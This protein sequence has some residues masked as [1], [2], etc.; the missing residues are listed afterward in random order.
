MLNSRNFCVQ[1]GGEE[2][3]LIIQC[4]NGEVNCNLV[5]C[6]RYLVVEIRRQAVEE[7]G[8]G[9]RPIHIVFIVHLPKILGGCQNFVGFQGG[10]WRSVHIDELRQSNE[11]MPCFDHLVDRSI[12]DLLQP[13]STRE[14]VVDS[15]AMD[16]DTPKEEESSFSS[17]AQSDQNINPTFILRNCLQK[18]AARVHCDSVNVNR[19]TRRIEILL[20][21]LPEDSSERK[22]EYGEYVVSLFLN[23][24]EHF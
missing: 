5:A 13:L 7:F 12:S 17:N 1:L 14:S 23:D 3:L 20:D 18:A 8:S 15:Q 16:V 2:G 11:Q 6:C 19:A 10:K 4:D 24:A 9:V 22:D 21:L